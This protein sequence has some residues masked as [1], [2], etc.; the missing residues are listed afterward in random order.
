MNDKKNSD[1]K[2]TC[3]IITNISKY[4]IYTSHFILFILSMFLTFKCNNEFDFGHFIVACCCPYIYII[5]I[6]HIF[7]ME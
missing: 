4:V 1:K 5:Y 7:K 2:S 6:S 3:H